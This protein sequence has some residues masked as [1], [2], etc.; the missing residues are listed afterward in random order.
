[1]PRLHHKGEWFD[2]IS[3][4]ALAE[5]EFESLLV[6]NAEIIREN[7]VIVPF[8]KTV[9]SPEGSA[10]ADLAIIARDYRHWVVVEVELAKHDLYSHVIPQVSILREASYTQECVSYIHAKNPALDPAKLAQMMLGDPPNVLVLVNKPDEEW[11]KELRRYGA[12]M[13]VFEIFRSLANR[14]IFVIDGEPPRQTQ[15]LLSELSFG[16]L[17]RCLSVSSPAALPVAPGETFAVL[18][19]EQ[20]TY[21]E[22]FQTATGVYL[23]P[24]GSMPIT[25]DR[26]YALLRTESGQYTIRALTKK[27]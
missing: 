25:P 17:P 5:T 14:H 3:P 12:H 9:Y 27:G 1:M 20:L 22:R 24:V 6:S 4:S 21:W 18:I 16:L 26:K 15:S 23:S 10:R 7:S 19:E 2:E 8:K 13:M 11:R